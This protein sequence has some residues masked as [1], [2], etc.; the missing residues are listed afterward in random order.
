MSEVGRE[1][2]SREPFCVTLGQLP[3]EALEAISERPRSYID[4]F[5]FVHMG[6]GYYE[7]WYAGELLAIWDGEDWCEPGIVGDSHPFDK[8]THRKTLAPQG[9]EQSQSDKTVGLQ[10]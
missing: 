4:E 10:G 5:T 1:I 3:E 7:A 2:E 9:C 6:A 8:L